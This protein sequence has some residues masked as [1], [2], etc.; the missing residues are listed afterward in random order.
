MS[1]KHFRLTITRMVPYAELNSNDQNDWG[2]AEEHL[3]YYDQVD[4]EAVLDS[5][6]DHYPI[7]VLDDFDIVVEEMVVKKGNDEQT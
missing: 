7:K 3:Y 4:E 5:F 2:E 6:H 1:D